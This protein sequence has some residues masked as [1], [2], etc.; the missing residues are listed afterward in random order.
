ML[1]TPRISH[2]S[3]TKVSS[4]NVM[5]ADNQQERLELY[6]R[7]LRDY[8]LDTINFVKIESEL[9]SDIKN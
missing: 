4:E 1:E 8:T 9:Y 6:S 5:S 7:I 2:Y 3:L